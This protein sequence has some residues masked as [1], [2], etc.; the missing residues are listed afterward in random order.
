MVLSGS[1]LGWF[2]VVHP[3]TQRYDASYES[4]NIICIYVLNWPG[5]PYI[6]TKYITYCQYYKKIEK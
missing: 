5:Y 1:S 4:Y 2:S 6:Y 3:K